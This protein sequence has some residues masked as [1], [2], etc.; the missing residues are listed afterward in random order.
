MRYLLGLAAVCAVCAAVLYAYNW[1][2]APKPK[3]HVRQMVRTK[4]GQREGQVLMVECL[5]GTPACTYRVRV[6]S[7]FS[8]LSPTLLVMNYGPFHTIP[9]Q[10]W[11]LEAIDR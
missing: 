2:N 1:D 5:L 10:E 9:M 11:E 6:Y 8:D 3:F 4:V 7:E